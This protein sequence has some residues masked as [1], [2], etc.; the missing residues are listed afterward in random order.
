MAVLLVAA[1]LFLLALSY[2]ERGKVGDKPATDTLADIKDASKE[3][4][5][6]IHTFLD[7]SGIKEGTAALLEEG[8]RR[9][10]A[11]PKPENGPT[12]TP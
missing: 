9:L 10:R 11:T 4:G 12:P 5:D 1:L 7:E 6:S 2:L 8:A 3:M